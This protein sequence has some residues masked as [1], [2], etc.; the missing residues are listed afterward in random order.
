MIHHSSPVLTFP[1]QLWSCVT[2]NKF[3][4]LLAW[5]YHNREAN[6]GQEKPKQHTRQCIRFQ[7][8]SLVISRTAAATFSF[9]LSLTNFCWGWLQLVLSLH[10]AILSWHKTIESFVFLHRGLVPPLDHYCSEP[11]EPYPL[12]AVYQARVKV[13]LSRRSRCSR[14]GGSRRCGS[15]CPG[16]RCPLVVPPPLLLFLGGMMWWVLYMVLA[17]QH[18]KNFLRVLCRRNMPFLFLEKLANIRADVLPTCQQ[19]YQLRWTQS[20]HLVTC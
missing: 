16:S 3:C 11:T 5:T 9:R 20:C 14:R 6:K 7:N 18:T 8:F 1:A 10:I 2:D 17:K 12:N 4:P 13:G 19:N 15:R